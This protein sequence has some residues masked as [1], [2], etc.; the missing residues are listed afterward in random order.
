MQQS[1]GRI[2]M[3]AL[4]CMLT[5]FCGFS[6]AAAKDT[7]QKAQGEPKIQFTELKHDFGTVNQNSE[8]R[9][10]FVFKNIGTGTLVIDKVKTSCGCTA[11][12]V[13][14]K[15][16]APG[17]E[18]KIDVVFKTGSGYGGRS[19]KTITVT[20]NDPEHPTTTLTVS[21]E[22]QV[23]LDLSPNR[24][25]FGQVKKNDQAVRYA[26]LTG[27]EKDRVKIT[28]VEV[29]N[30]FIR[31]EIEPKG[32]ENDPQHQIRVTLLPGMNVG[33][34]TERILLR[35]DHPRVQELTLYVMGEVIGNIVATP[36]FV[37]FGMFEPG[38]AL[39]RVVTLRAAG[40]T[41]FRISDVQSTLPDLITVLETVQQGREY[42]IR[43]RLSEKF[44]G[45]IL[46]GQLIVMTD[47]TDQPRIEINVFGRKAIRPQKTPVPQAR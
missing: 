8:L 35:T 46:R 20:S 16:I 30:E 24:I 32:F 28:S 7:V 5:L 17:G 11:A 38:T 29:K 43:A 6:R 25:L 23:V 36:N 18:G 12:L 31:V 9:H 45:E 26:A 40:D 1:Y 4:F 39:E 27:T 34:F 10:T 41:S 14:D 37:H 19:E 42:R 22:V 15:E 13:S 44:S 21:A 33:R 3:Y 2:W 47:D